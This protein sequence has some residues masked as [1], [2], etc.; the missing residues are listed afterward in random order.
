MPKRGQNKPFAAQTR[1]REYQNSS[2]PLGMFSPAQAHAIS[3]PAQTAGARCS[4]SPA[5]QDCSVAP[6]ALREHFCL[7]CHSSPAHHIP[8][9]RRGNE[10]CRMLRRS[11]AAVR[12]EGST[13]L[14]HLQAWFRC[15]CHPAEWDSLCCSTDGFH[16]TAA[17]CCKEPLA[18]AKTASV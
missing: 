7:F 5:S 18:S 3:P 2:S 1:S 15:W 17:D 12:R 13:S 9:N 8:R 10:V 14:A 16:G 11:P 4:L 6:H